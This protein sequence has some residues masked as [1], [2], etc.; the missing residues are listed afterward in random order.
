[1]N[2][3]F[4]SVL[5]Q[6]N[7]QQKIERESYGG[8]VIEIPKPTSN[9]DS[10]TSPKNQ[11]NHTHQELSASGFHNR[12]ATRAGTWK[13]MNL[14]SEK[15]RL[16]QECEI[17]L[18]RVLCSQ[19][20]IVVNLKINGRNERCLGEQWDDGNLRKTTRVQQPPGGQSKGRMN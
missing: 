8:D 1:M 14:L 18:I 11:S 7:K 10:K 17:Y 6:F 2:Y 20:I 19:V 3:L 15:N 9:G 16:F 12:P 5:I 13:T 4:L